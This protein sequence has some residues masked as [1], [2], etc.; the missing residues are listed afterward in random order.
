[1]ARRSERVAFSMAGNCIYVRDDGYSGGEEDHTHSQ[2]VLGLVGH[3]FVRLGGF[4]VEGGQ[5]FDCGFSILR[6]RTGLERCWLAYLHVKGWKNTPWI[7]DGFSLHSRRLCTTLKPP[8]M[9]ENI[10]IDSSCRQYQDPHVRQSSSP[11]EGVSWR[12]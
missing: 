11:W 5:R 3:V 12:M 6:F 9:R 2:V 10:R 8:R 1:M 4:P 7:R